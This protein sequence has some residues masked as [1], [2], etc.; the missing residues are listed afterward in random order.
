MI[1]SR[2]ALLLRSLKL[3]APAAPS[4]LGRTPI[5]TR[6]TPSMPFTNA[7]RSFSTGLDTRK[8]SESEVVGAAPQSTAL[9]A[10]YADEYYNTP[11]YVRSRGDPTKRAFTYMILGTSKFIA[12]SVIRVAILKL[13]WTMSASA[14]VLALGQVEVELGKIAP[15]QNATVKWRGKPVFIRHRTQEEIDLSRKDDSADMRDPERDEDRAPTPEWVV[16]LGV[17]THLGCVPIANAGEYLGWFCPC[18]GSHYDLSGRIRKGPAP[19]NLEIPTYQLM[20]GNT[21]VLLG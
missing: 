13:L 21:K 9:P 11:H 4:Y 12:A 8:E 18:H 1:A 15:G 19:L 3:G 14:E 17:C 5:H 16:V 20:E 6:F 10:G 7:W 2:G